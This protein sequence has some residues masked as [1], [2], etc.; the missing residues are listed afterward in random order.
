VKS[1]PVFSFIPP[2]ISMEELRD[3]VFHPGQWFFPNPW[4]GNAG[5]ENMYAQTIVTIFLTQYPW[6]VVIDTS[7]TG[8]PRASAGTEVVCISQPQHQGVEKVCRLLELRGRR[9]GESIAKSQARNTRTNDMEC[10]CGSRMFRV[11]E[12]VEERTGRKREIREWKWW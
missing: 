3:I 2:N 6:E 5:F 4:S 11:R 10:L 9:I 8:L 1:G 7:R 12:L